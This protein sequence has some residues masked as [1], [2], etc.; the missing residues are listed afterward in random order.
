MVFGVIPIGGIRGDLMPRGKR[1]VIERKVKDP[2]ISKLRSIKAVDLKT[3]RTSREAELHESI[4]N[5]VKQAQSLYAQDKM[6]RDRLSGM[7]LVSIEEA[8]DEVKKAGIPI[9]FRAFGGRVERHSIRSEKVGS[10]RVIPRQVVNDWIGL[11]R[12]YYTVR[13]AYEKLK[14]HEEINMR[15]FIGR[16]EKNSIPSIKIGP[17]RWIPKDAIDGLTHI[18]KNYY[19]VSEA[20][21]HLQSKG[22]KINRNA[23]ERRLDRSRIPHEK[24][25]GRRVIAKEVMEELVSKEIALSSRRSL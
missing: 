20:M 6:D 25:G 12:D 5:V 2:V 23:F 11:H 3:K 9:S 18:A 22:I 24:I 1:I 19:D 4:A 13:Q 21:T 16:V 14:S 8:F 15:A 10:K 7:G 17:A